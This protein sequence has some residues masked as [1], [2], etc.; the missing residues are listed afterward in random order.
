MAKTRMKTL[1]T[2]K[3]RELSAFKKQDVKILSYDDVRKL[4]IPFEQ[5]ENYG[6]E[7]G[8]YFRS[9][10]PSETT[11]A[12]NYFGNNEGAQRFI[13]SLYKA[14]AK[15][16]VVSGIGVSDGVVYADTLF[17][18]MK[19]GKRASVLESVISLGSPDEFDRIGNVLRLWW[20]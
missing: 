3:T 14:G 19:K 2:M 1:G 16:V 10:E 20:D 11:F 17:V 8:E 18:E 12:V 5:T 13:N 4:D 9:T 7:A 15:K 6:V